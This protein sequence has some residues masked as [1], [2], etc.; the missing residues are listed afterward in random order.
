MFEN[1]LEI[2]A[3]NLSYS[4][5]FVLIFVTILVTYWLGTF[6]LTLAAELDLPGPKPLPFLG[7]LFDIRKRGGI[8]KALLEYTREYGKHFVIYQGRIPSIV[9][10]D[11]ETLR[12][13]LV[14]NFTTFRNRFPP[15]NP[16]SPLDSGLFFA[17]DHK[18]KRIRTTITPSFSA[19]KIKQ[20][21]PLI[22]EAC[23]V[24]MK[25][26]RKEVADTCE[27]DKQNS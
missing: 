14:K 20:M 6:N 15:F 3:I 12:Q 5:L 27:Y 13:V 21:V 26:L 16:P 19:F 10:V 7:N 17:K 25:K 1:V 18:W 2:I 22:E 8:H 23:E 11:P 24:M 4:A 9:I